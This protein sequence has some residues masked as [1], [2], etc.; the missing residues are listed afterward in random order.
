MNFETLEQKLYE[1]TDSEKRYQKKEYLDYRQ[2]SSSVYIDNTEVFQFYMKDMIRG[3][4]NSQYRIRKQSRFAPVPVHITDVI[5]LNYI[6]H[7]KCTH[8]VNGKKITLSE[9]DL[10]LIDTQATHMVDSSDYADIIISINIEQNFFKKHFFNHLQNQSA[11][12]KFLFQAISDTNNHNQFLLF[13]CKE[14]QSLKLLFQQLLVEV[15]EPK[16]L[17]EDY[18]NHLLQLIFLELIRSFSIESNLINQNSHKKQLTLEILA[19]I[20]DNYTH[21]TLDSCALQ[22]GYN[23]SYFSSLV[24]EY[25]GQTFIKILQK[26][27]LESTLPALLHSKCSIRDIALEAGFSNLNH[28]YSLF[29]KSYGMTPATY[30]KEQK[31]ID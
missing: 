1:L 29:K 30:R 21:A 24:K 19:Y 23:A 12:T 15:F 14:S 27:R 28:Y 26:K 2:S 9:G 13:H 18:K 6:Y 11:L 5:E 7:G 10:I 4:N 31:S 25:T 3:S 20:E 17:D 16:F 22:F 8:Y